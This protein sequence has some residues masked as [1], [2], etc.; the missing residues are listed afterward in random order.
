M[1]AERRVNSPLSKPYYTSGE[2]AQEILRRL[3]KIAV[4][5]Q[6]FPNLLSQYPKKTP[7][8]ITR[9]PGPLGESVYFSIMNASFS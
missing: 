9:N 6:A 3:S 8:R 5:K 4:V 1:F 7:G 2:E